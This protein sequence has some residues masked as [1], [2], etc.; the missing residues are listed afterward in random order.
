MVFP[1]RRVK[2]VECARLLG[3]KSSEQICMLTEHTYDSAVFEIFA[4]Y[5]NNLSFIE[6]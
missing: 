2:L 3:Q 4:Q 5:Y 6:Q 1:L